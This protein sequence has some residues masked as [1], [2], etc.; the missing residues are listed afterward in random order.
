MSEQ[1]KTTPLKKDKYIFHVDTSVNK[2]LLHEI[3]ND[4]E[5]LSENDKAFLEQAI[6]Q[7]TQ[8]MSIFTVKKLTIVAR[9]NSEGSFD[10]GYAA[11]S[12]E[13]NFSKKIGVKIA[14][15]RLH[16]TSKKHIGGT[17]KLEESQQNVESLKDI[18]FNQVAIDIE[19]HE[20]MKKNNYNKE[21]ANRKNNI[22]FQMAYEIFNTSRALLKNA[23]TD[24]MIETSEET[25]SEKTQEKEDQATTK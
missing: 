24:K 15:Q 12:F 22:Y 7:V 20:T 14:E 13:D 9:R 19:N 4:E 10:I 3:K 8:K 2:Q 21:L 17:I 5:I 25:S 18:I 1:T 6:K 11:C 23:V 16:K